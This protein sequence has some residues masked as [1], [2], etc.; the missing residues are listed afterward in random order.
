M[1]NDKQINSLKAKESGRAFS[2][3]GHRHSGTQLCR[4]WSCKSSRE[5]SLEFHE[6]R[7][8]KTVSGS[9]SK[10]VQEEA[11]LLT[12]QV[13][14]HRQ[15][16]SNREGGHAVRWRENEPEKANALPK[17]TQLNP[18]LHM[19]PKLLFPSPVLVTPHYR[20]TRNSMYNSNDN[21][22]S[23]QGKTQEIKAKGI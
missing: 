9:L 17:V 11:A 16:R 13:W 14:K 21:D 18:G 1:T 5:N 12:S 7:G 3:K 23:N 22:Q 6:P 19:E 10:K 15:I 4:A 8:R 20:A 2:A